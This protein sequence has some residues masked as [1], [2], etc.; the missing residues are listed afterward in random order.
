M[1]LNRTTGCTP[2]P[3]IFVAL[4]IASLPPDMNEATDRGS[5]FVA[6]D[7]PHSSK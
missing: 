4:L 3:S 7:Q 1:K 5:V 6:V 2:H